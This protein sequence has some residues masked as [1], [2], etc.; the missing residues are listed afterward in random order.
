MCTGFS[1][2]CDCYWDNSVWTKVLT[3][4]T[5]QNCCPWS[6]SAWLKT[7]ITI[8]SF[9]VRKL[10]LTGQLASSSVKTSACEFPTTIRVGNLQCLPISSVQLDKNFHADYQVLLL[11]T[12]WQPS[13][14]KR[15]WGLCVCVWRGGSHP[16]VFILR[17]IYKS[18]CFRIQGLT[19][20]CASPV[21]TLSNHV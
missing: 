18:L 10:A 4:P 16:C 14:E 17:E 2:P 3:Q 21:L 15:V 7:L 8:N 11:K 1:S 6:H 12:R 19:R 9:A 20:G 5:D 13:E